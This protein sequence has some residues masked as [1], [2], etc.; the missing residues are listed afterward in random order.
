MSFAVAAC[1]LCVSKAIASV[2]N[3]SAISRKEDRVQTEPIPAEPPPARPRSPPGGLTLAAI[4]A[5]PCVPTTR[6]CDTL[7]PARAVVPISASP[8]LVERFEQISSMVWC[9]SRDSRLK[10]VIVG[11]VDEQPQEAGKLADRFR[12]P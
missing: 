6:D 5:S 11:S 8:P 10:C 12:L 7:P 9:D 2:R 1:R 3:F 4:G